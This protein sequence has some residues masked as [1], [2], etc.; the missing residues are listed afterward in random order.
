MKENGFMLKNKKQ[1]IPRIN[2]NGCWLYWWHTLLANTPTQAES[3]LHSLE[4]AAGG[5][6]LCVNADKTEYMCFNQKGNIFTLNGGSLKPEDKFT[7]PGSSVP[8]TENDINVQL[9]KAWTAI[10]KLPIIWKQDLSDKIK[11]IFSKVAVMSI[12]LYGCTTWALTKRI[13]KKL[14]FHLSIGFNWV[15]LI[16]I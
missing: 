11:C 16:F 4:Q 5:I 7:Y 13:E 3:L 2:Y 1:M 12:L 9:L 15:F 8:S 6:G 14:E 10:D